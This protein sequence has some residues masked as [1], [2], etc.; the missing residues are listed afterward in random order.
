MSVLTAPT[1]TGTAASALLG[2][3][4]PSPAGT[5]ESLEGLREPPAI[6]LPAWIQVLWFSQR[7]TG[8]VFRHRAK[9]GDV[10]SAHGY[11]RGRPVVTAHPDHVRALFTAP[12]EQ[13]PTLA[14]ESPLRPILGPASVLTANGPRHLRQRKLLL[15]PFHGEA[16]ARYEEAI[17]K[18]ARREIDRWPVGRAF[19][20][21]PRMQAITLDVI[22]AGIFGIEGR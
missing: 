4:P 20:L 14:A 22:M 5:V 13:V 17:R 6:R 15:P 12:P 10:W 3:A 1:P 11:V 16:V 9:F 2:S 21:A 18:A 19:S 8:F 7:Q